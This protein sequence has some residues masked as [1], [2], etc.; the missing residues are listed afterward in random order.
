[1]NTMN[2][3]LIWR[4]LSDLHRPALMHLNFIAGV[5]M[6]HTSLVF[7]RLTFTESVRSRTL[8][9]VGV[10]LSRATRAQRSAGKEHHGAKSKDTIELMNKSPQNFERLV[11]ICMDSYDSEK[12]RILQ[13]FSRSTRFAF[14]CTAQI[15]NFQQ[16]TSCVF[17]CIFSKNFAKIFKILSFFSKILMN[18][19]QNFTKRSA[20][21]WENEE[22]VDLQEIF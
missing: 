20:I 16:K 11:L 15:S 9:A 21:F 18:F 13:H 7:H 12:G 4:A 2:R 5:T 19:A 6:N 1:M 8:F 17:F 14:L 22:N 10:W 3:T